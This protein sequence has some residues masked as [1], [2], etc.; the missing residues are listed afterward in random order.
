M[1]SWTPYAVV[2]FVGQFGDEK[3][4]IKPWIS[5][6]PALCAKVWYCNILHNLRRFNN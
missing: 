6:L 5:A 3:T 1:V 4:H 2:T